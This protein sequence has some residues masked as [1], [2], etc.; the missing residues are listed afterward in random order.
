VRPAAVRRRSVSVS[1]TGSL[2]LVTLGRVGSLP[3]PRKGELVETSRLSSARS[4]HA[5]QRRRAAATSPRITSPRSNVVR[6]PGGPASVGCRRGTQP[7]ARGARQAGRRS[8][9]DERPGAHGGRLE[10]RP[11]SAELRRARSVCSPQFG[12]SP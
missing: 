10:S 9:R 11:G 4:A 3:L 6:L 7:G 12:G 1:A 2:P 5:A 8:R